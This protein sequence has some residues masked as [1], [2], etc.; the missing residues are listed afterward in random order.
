MKQNLI[1]KIIT[2]IAC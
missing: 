1:M 2:M